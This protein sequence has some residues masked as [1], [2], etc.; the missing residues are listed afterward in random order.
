MP[1]LEAN[2]HG[3]S[4]PSTP[5]ARCRFQG[6]V[7]D[8]KYLDGVMDAPLRRITIAII[9]KKR[10]KAELQERRMRIIVIERR[11]RIE[12]ERERE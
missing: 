10:I 8:I 4:R 2:E 11:K 1:G 3:N 12:G 5:T 9:S 6:L 7:L